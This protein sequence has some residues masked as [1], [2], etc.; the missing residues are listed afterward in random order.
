[1][2]AAAPAA[3][4][5][6]SSPHHRPRP[7]SAYRTSASSHTHSDSAGASA[8]SSPRPAL[9]GSGCVLRRSHVRACA[10]AYHRPHPPISRRPRLPSRSRSRSRTRRRIRRWTRLCRA[11]GGRC[12]RLWVV[13]SN[14]LVLGGM[15][16]CGGGW[17]IYLWTFSSPSLHC[18]PR[19]TATELISLAG[20]VRRA[21]GG[22]LV[23]G[24][25]FG[26][27]W[28]VWWSRFGWRRV[29]RPVVAVTG[30]RQTP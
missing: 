9:C 27:Q 19:R 10:C 4:P 3:H 14:Q 2:R 21:G 15:V 12:S 22:W 29:A 7:S 13:V 30:G 25:G 6:P 1:M 26:W 28:M 5:V 17:W 23:S 20:R 24:F 18:R 11:G 16:E 8:G